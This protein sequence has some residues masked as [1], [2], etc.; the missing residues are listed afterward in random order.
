V[1][2]APLIKEIPGDANLP[3]ESEN[4]KFIPLLNYGGAGIKNKLRILTTLPANLI[5]IHKS[6]KKLDWLQ[7]RAPTSM[8]LYLL[9][10][11]S[12]FRKNNKWVKYAGN[13]VQENPPLSYA[14]Q[15]W[16]LKN[17]FQHSFVTI[18]GKWP[19]Q[20]SHLLTFEN[21]CLYQDDLEKGKLIASQKSFKD[22]L[23]L[24]FVGRLELEKGP[25]TILKSLK[26]SGSATEHIKKVYIIGSGE[27]KNTLIKEAAELPI[28]VNIID[29]LSRLKLTEV[30]AESHLFILPSRASEGFP[31]V[32]AEAA[33]YGAVPVVSNVS[34]IAQYVKND[35][36][37]IVLKTTNE[38]ELATVLKDLFNDREK[39]KSLSSQ[40]IEIARPFT[41]E[42]YLSKI[43]RQIIN[44]TTD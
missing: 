2:I 15:R 5:T 17:N 3:Y 21:P 4:I 7:F 1:H 22:G 9:P 41:F 8:G 40:A 14:F 24:C 28:E 31:K 23:V 43:K 34:S 29:G 33:C 10:Y 19:G 39:L 16:W 25:L 37:G 11:L 35:L 36:T 27:L 32:I 13:W 6:I 38:N 20:Q 44:S 30:Y 18:N 26:L 42:N 12:A